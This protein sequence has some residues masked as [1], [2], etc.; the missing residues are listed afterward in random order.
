MHDGRMPVEIP[1]E[2]ILIRE[3]GVV[4]I[5]VVV[6]LVYLPPVG[7]SALEGCVVVGNVG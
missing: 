7:N 3:S 5:A 1:L 6:V 4:D 2:Q